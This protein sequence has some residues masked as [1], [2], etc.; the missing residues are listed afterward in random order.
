MIDEF[1]A[2]VGSHKVALEVGV[3]SAER[4][5]FRPKSQIRMIVTSAHHP[6]Q[7][8]SRSHIDQI[9]VADRQS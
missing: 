5:V 8:D 4:P 2:D 7:I 6:N 3:P 1:D 9:P